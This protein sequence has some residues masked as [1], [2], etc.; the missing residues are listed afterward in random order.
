MYLRRLL[1][2]LLPLAAGPALAAQAP[3]APPA[4]PCAGPQYHQFDFWAGQWDVYGANGKQVANSLIEK[5]YGCGIRENWMPFQG[6]GGGSLN[7]YVPGARHW[8]QFW[9]DSGGTRALFVGGLKGKDMVIEGEWGGP[10]VRITYTPNV[11]GS[12]RQFGVQSTDG[13]KSWASSF[14]L[15]YRPHPAGAPFPTAQ[16]KGQ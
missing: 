8:E 7:I 16:A 11:D 4:D 5:V 1:P 2:A 12:V 9:I 14:D 13:G 6:A 15:L 3:A 10:L